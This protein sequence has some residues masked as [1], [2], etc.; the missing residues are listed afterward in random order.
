MI[1]HIIQRN[2]KRQLTLPGCCSLVRKYCGVFQPHLYSRTK[3]FAKEFATALDRLNVPVLIELYPAREEP[4]EGISSET[5]YE[6]DE[7]RRSRFD[8]KEKAY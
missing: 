4:I 3:D 8:R 7:E 2:S 6:T 5:I 1:M